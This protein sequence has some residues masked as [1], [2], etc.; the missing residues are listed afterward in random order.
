MPGATSRPTTRSGSRST[1][2]KLKPIPREPAYERGGLRNA[3]VE[4]GRKMF[5]EIGAGELSLR[6]LAR[7][8]GVSEAAPSRHFSG[9]EELL[10][11]IAVS[12]FEELAQQ[13]IEI[14]AQKL[15]PLP[16]ARAMMLSYVRY[17]QS[18]AGLFD[19][20]TGPRLLQQFV[21][22]DVEGISNISYSYFAES[23]FEL[24]LASGWAQKDLHYVSHAAWSMEHGVAAL[25]LAGRIPRTDSNI[26]VERMIEFS[27][28]MFL[29]A[30]V[31]G[32]QLLRRV[33]GRD[34]IAAQA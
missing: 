16:K 7:R 27:I 19:L 24:A 10:A 13:R 3:L 5:E 2:K 22:R 30:V 34:L 21:R 15:E 9:K 29:A 31:A 12:G 4:E 28:E 25:I 8:L 23:V 6:A 11:A 17:A 1:A 32:P 18:H 26:E 33:R 20:M 14:A